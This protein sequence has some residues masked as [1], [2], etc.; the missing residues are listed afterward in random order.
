ML[1]SGVPRKCVRDGK[2]KLAWF[3]IEE[4]SIDGRT[5]IESHGFEPLNEEE[6]EG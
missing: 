6:A 2:R 4:G 5:I 3:K 1:P